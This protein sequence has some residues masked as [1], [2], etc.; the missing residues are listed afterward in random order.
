[1]EKHRLVGLKQ[2]WRMRV[3]LDSVLPGKAWE[4]LQL[5]PIAPVCWGYIQIEMHF[6]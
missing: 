2:S 5:V 6:L 1:M 3:T 4:R